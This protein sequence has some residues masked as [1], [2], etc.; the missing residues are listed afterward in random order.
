MINDFD[1]SFLFIVNSFPPINNQNSIRALELSKRLIKEKIFP[2]ILTRRVVRKEP[3]DDD[4]IDEIPQNL[5]VIKTRVIELKRKYSLRTL[6]FKIIMHFFYLFY[7]IHWIP[8]GYLEGKKI[9]KNSKN[10]KF[11]YSTGPPHYSHII[12]YLLYRKFKIPYI[13]EYRDPW[14]Y[15]PY[16]VRKRRNIDNII[17]LKIEQ[18]I[19]KSA[20]VIIAIS[21]PLKRLII[22]SSPSVKQNKVYVIENGLNLKNI[23]ESVFNNNKEIT[24]TF[25][26]KLYGQRNINPLLKIIA[27]LKTKGEFKN[28][29]F[30]FK[31][32]GKYNHEYLKKQIKS[33]NIQ[34]LVYLGP[35]LSRNQLLEEINK[36]YLTVHIGENLNYPTIGFKVWDY[37]SCRKKILYLGL[38]DSYTSNFLKKNEFGIVIPINDINRGKQV[39]KKLLYEI[40]NREFPN[41]IAKE[42]L[43]T[44]SWDIK[45]KKLI[46]CIQ[47]EF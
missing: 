31:I 9:L 37:L 25:I 46:Q 6:F 42:K 13:I 45:A 4:L 39:F 43:E 10:I 38:E 22:K 33:L 8:F 36:C 19:L 2:I 47:E 12:T 21:N 17:S 7:Y 28:V 5:E 15:N 24:F 26:G 20:H 40:K 16:G 11:L 41:I 35:F 32:F 23:N 44:F 14:N 3:K 27:L 18:K 29:N 30:L 34:D 1:T